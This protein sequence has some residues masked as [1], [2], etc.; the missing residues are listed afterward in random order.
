MCS[1]AV[2]GM[3]AYVV[4]VDDLFSYFAWNERLKGATVS[5]SMFYKVKSEFLF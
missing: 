2:E 4:I 1:A 5:Y 3:A